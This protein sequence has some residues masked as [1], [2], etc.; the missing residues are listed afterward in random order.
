MPGKKTDSHA[1]IRIKAPSIEPR[2][3]APARIVTTRPVTMSPQT[4]TQNTTTLQEIAR[5]NDR[6]N[7]ATIR[8]GT[9]M[10]APASNFRC[11][12]NR[13]MG[14]TQANGTAIKSNVNHSPAI[15]G[16]GGDMSRDRNATKLVSPKDLKSFTFSS[17]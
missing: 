2:S 6:V 11:L 10:A 14:R 16:L 4:T 3:T 1:T 7:V 17:N 8:Q 5:D 12:S 15:H 13:Y 9:N